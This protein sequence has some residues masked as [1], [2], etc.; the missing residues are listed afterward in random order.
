MGNTIRAHHGHGPVAAALLSAVRGERR[1][2]LPRPAPSQA[3][4]QSGDGA[5]AL[6][7][8]ASSKAQ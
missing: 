6:A 2:A 1:A 7:F 3:T 5:A 4:A 8:H